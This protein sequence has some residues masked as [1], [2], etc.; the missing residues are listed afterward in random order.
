MTFTGAPATSV[1]PDDWP[2]ASLSRIVEAGGVRWHV[3]RT[4]AGA[5]GPTI[6]LLHGAGAS[7]HS[8]RGL[9]EVFGD[10][11]DA[12]AVDLPGHGF[13]SAL[14]AARSD[15][16]G[17]ARALGELVEAME[18]DCA[19][20]V[21]HSAGAAVAVR[22]VLDVAPVAVPVL[23]ING[24]LVALGGF[25]GRWF[26][27]A[28]RVVAERGPLV[29]LIVHQARRRGAV[30]RL[31]EGT[32]S[33]FTEADLALYR[34]LLLREAHVAGVMRMMANWDL[35]VLEPRLV[36]LAAP[37]HLLDGDQDRTLRES[38]RRRVRS[39]LAAAGVLASDVALEGLGHLAHEEAPERVAREIAR[40][41]AAAPTGC[42]TVSEQPGDTGSG[43]FDGRAGA[44]G[45]R[46][47]ER[48]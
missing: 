21:G 37:M 39:R 33:R 6:L 26:A 5:G 19:L 13:S 8:W 2:C 48:G 30:A 28:A 43:A 31:L 45:E 42:D 25:A 40:V 17:F 32:G 18:L 34:R 46:E 36:E 47:Q 35:P 14:P 7:T 44:A 9:L 20:I 1:V 15:S 24:A 10:E 38:Y 23:A 16:L 27:P 22:Y 11:I 29:R 41:L 4:G 3:Q 12:V